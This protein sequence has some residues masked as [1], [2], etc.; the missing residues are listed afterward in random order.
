MK[1]RY[2]LIIVAIAI[3]IAA[4]IGSYGDSSTYVGF[5]EA[6]KSPGKEFHVVGELVRDKPMVYDPIKDP[7]YFSFFVK[8]SLGAERQ[9]IFHQPKP[10]DFELSD[11]I[12]L[13]GKQSENGT[14]TASQILLK[15]PSKYEGED[16]AKHPKS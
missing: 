2:I 13:V 6:A 15:C 10:N 5:D 7:N 8:D 1:I 4:V 11:R 12:V 3:A 14:F 16:P 9:V